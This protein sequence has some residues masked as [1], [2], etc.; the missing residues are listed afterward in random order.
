MGIS[1]KPIDVNECGTCGAKDADS[2][3]CG[4]SRTNLSSDD[5]KKIGKSYEAGQTIYFEGDPSEGVYCLKTGLI[6]I[7]KTDING[8]SA[9][10]RLIQPGEAFG[11]RSFLA[12]EGHAGSAE[13]LVDC[14]VCFLPK[15]NLTALLSQ[16]PDIAFR[17]TRRVAQDLR[18]IEELY[19]VTTTQPVRKRLARLLLGLRTRYDDPVNV[20]K[21]VLELP[22]SRQELAAAI[23]TRPE[24]IART[25][26]KLEDDTLA[27]FKGRTVTIPSHQKL[28]DDINSE[29]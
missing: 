4:L 14:S 12:N 1:E 16:S 2:S 24:T 11:H 8:N 27:F 23:G 22:L 7:R 21:I 13:V 25:I 5:V 17:F 15:A 26:K 29:D 28:L 10:V 20:D 9:V 6:A 18:E 19:L 3:L